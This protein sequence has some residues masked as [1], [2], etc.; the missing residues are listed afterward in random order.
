MSAVGIGLLIIAHVAD[1]TTFMVMV[2]RHGLDSE[3]N[4]LVVTLAA[5]H[6]LVLLTMAKFATVL[7]VASVFLVV[8]R[9]RPRLAATV[10]VFGVLV[11]GLGA[12][13]NIITI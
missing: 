7:L 13:S 2:A 11:G 3:L 6:G 4:P 1:Y 5:D 9:T 10:L 12:F 8:G